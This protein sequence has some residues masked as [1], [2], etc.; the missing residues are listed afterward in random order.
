MTATA[1][2]IPTWQG[3]YADGWQ[4]LIV[5]ASFAHPAK[6]A[7]GLIHRLDRH[8]FE[9]GYVREGDTVLDP[10]GGVALGALD[11]MTYGLRYAGR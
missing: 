2:P 3:C 5:P 8:L 11:A 6:Y 4:D 1:V 7:R 10:F 9:H